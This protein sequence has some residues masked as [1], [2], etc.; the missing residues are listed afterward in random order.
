LKAL[1]AEAFEKFPEDMKKIKE[2]FSKHD[3]P[4]EKAI[5]EKTFKINTIFISF[6]VLNW[7]F[8]KIKLWLNKIENK[9]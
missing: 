1:N 3:T 6:C 9:K 2:K 8:I 4:K 5:L 7:F